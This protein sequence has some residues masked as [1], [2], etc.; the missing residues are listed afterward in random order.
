MTPPAKTL[1][2]LPALIFS[3]RWLQLPLCVEPLVNVGDRVQ[4]VRPF[5]GHQLAF[6]RAQFD[7]AVERELVEA[8]HGYA[9]RRKQDGRGL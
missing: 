4:I 8:Q 9:R 1:S 7:V 3:S 5:G 6:Q 2:P